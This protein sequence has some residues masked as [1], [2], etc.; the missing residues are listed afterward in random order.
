MLM[1]GY[2]QEIWRC[3]YFW[4]SLVRM[5][6]RTRYR[7]SILGLGWS[8][9]NP[10]M[11]TAVLCTVFCPL[12]GL[13]WTE[14]A[15][16]IL[17]GMACWQLFSSAVLQGCT[18]YY[19]NESY[20]RQQPMPLA[21]YPLRVVLG[22][23]IHFLIALGVVV[24]FVYTVPS[25]LPTP[26][27]L[28]LLLSLLPAVALFFVFAWSVAIIAATVNVFFQDTQHLSEVFLQ[29]LFYLT[30]I[31]WKTDMLQNRQEAISYL[32]MLNPIS[33]FLDLVRVPILENRVAPIETYLTVVCCVLVTAT[34]AAL[35]M[36]R[37]QKR[38]IFHL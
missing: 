14:Y 13:S 16:Y 31:I 2:M 32:V 34:T 37:Y 1:L 17:G 19:Q 36:R 30:P 15:P 24:V 21:I 23:T 6:L 27:P 7:R 33:R 9:L 5:D 38:I 25:A 12:T 4:S 35:L 29:M 18:A 28:R 26:Q 3:R 11:M 20:I 10:I 8:L 22:A